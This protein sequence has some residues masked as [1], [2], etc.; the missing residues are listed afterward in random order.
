MEADVPL[1]A[2]VLDHAAERLLVERLTPGAYVVH[3]RFAKWGVSEA[4]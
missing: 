4:V 2:D 1:L 3:G